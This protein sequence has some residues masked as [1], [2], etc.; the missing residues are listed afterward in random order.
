MTFADQSQAESSAR[1]GEMST[2]AQARDCSEAS[3]ADAFRRKAV[4]LLRM[5]LESGDSW[6][7]AE[8]RQL[9]NEFLR[10]A[11]ELETT[12]VR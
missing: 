6:A 10:R 8:L 3:T 5:A 9:A 1:E 7:G 4:A 11:E 12:P 2:L